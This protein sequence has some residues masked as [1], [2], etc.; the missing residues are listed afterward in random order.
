M[1]IKKHNRSVASKKTLTVNTDARSKKILSKEYR[2]FVSNIALRHVRDNVI[3]RVYSLRLTKKI[4]LGWLAIILIIIASVGVTRELATRSF[5][6]SSF[7]N[8]GT[9][10]EAFIGNIDNLNPLFAPFR[11]FT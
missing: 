6:D 4:I 2:Y 3:R 8:G 10:S 9:F 1:D 7:I 11:I 5:S